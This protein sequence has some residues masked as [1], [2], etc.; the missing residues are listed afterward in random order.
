MTIWAKPPLSDVKSLLPVD[1][2]R[3]KTPLLKFRN[4]IPHLQTSPSLRTADVFPEGER[5]TTGNTSAVARRRLKLVS[6]E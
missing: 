1:V 4:V 3:S 6:I 2:R 5:A